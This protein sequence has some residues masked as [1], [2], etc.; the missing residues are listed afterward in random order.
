MIGGGPA[1]LAAAET[2]AM[3]G[4]SVTIYDRM[5][6]VGR[7]FQLAGRGGLNMTHS[8]P[9]D[10]FLTRYGPAEAPLTPAVRAFAPDAL[11]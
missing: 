1:G 2:L 7:K 11:R 5:P 10:R 3:A 6:T 9:L 4:R 8:E